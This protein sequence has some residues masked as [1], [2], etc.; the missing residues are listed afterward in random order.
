METRTIMTNFMA[1]AMITLLI[2]LL[3]SATATIEGYT[4]STVPYP[5]I[6]GTVQVSLDNSTWSSTVEA[7]AGQ[8][9]YFRTKLP[10]G[11]EISRLSIDADNTGPV[12]FS[13]NH[14]TMPN[15]NVTV[16]AKFDYT[17]LGF[18]DS[19]TVT[20][21][22]GIGTG[23]PIVYQFDPETAA[24]NS[25]SARNCQ[26]YYVNYNTIG[27][28][29]YGDYYPTSFTLPA[30]IYFSSWGNWGNNGYITL[31]SSQTTFTANYSDNPDDAY[32][33]L[34]PTAYT[35][36]NSDY[37]DITCTLS[38][39]SLGQVMRY[40]GAGWEY[41]Q[42]EG[43]GFYMNGGTLTD[44]AGHSIPFLVDT[45]Y[46]FK[47]ETRKY[48]GDIP[49]SQG[50]EFIMSVYINPNDYDNAVPGTYTGELFYEGYWFPYDVPGASGSITLTLVI[51]EA[52][53]TLSDNAENNYVIANN[54]N[55]L[56]NVK[57][58]GRT[59]YRDGNWNTLC[60]PFHFN[61]EGSI[62]D[63]IGVTLMELDTEAGNYD[64]PT[65]F[66]NGTLY[67]NFK[68]AGTT[69]KAGKPYIIKW[70]KPSNYDSNPR[71]YDISN[72]VFGGVTINS[73]EPT[74]ITS[75][76][77]TVS[78][79]GCYSPFTLDANDRTNLYLG[80]GNTLY[81]PSTDVTINSC[82]A[83]VQL[84]GITAA[85]ISSE[86][87]AFV[88]NFGDDDDASGII[89]IDHSPLT[90]DHSAD[91]WYTID[92][93]KLSGKPTSKGIYIKDGKKMVVK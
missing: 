43:I 49:S 78:F 3:Q 20:L 9:V 93:R 85:D 15:D 22:P 52:E 13:G 76:D 75:K 81:Y 47:A 71:R 64:H 53:V 73:T 44:G 38:T 62:L 33:S 26:F 88:R 69:I 7:P 57:L 60:L 37:T 72:P 74:T 10:S 4:V 30:G 90:I 51:P 28:R 46:H 2:V 32:Y 77:G 8:T 12:N 83:Y 70:T 61:I 14:F 56:A 41:V 91:A 87:N 25:S 65:G 50:Q 35:I 67:L 54:Q 39:L 82:R 29:L 23:T 89:D 45:P 19:Y 24:P 42:T 1:R 40:T 34:S 92:G 21:S 11:Y 48:Q 59:L 66:N 58:D 63:K 6:E 36:A 16:S 5:A 55:K 79:V 86:V 18:T 80:A 31:T 84:N 68:P 27:F 17:G